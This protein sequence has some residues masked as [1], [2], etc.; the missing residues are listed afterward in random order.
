LLLL[1]HIAQLDVL[2]WGADWTGYSFKYQLLQIFLKDLPDEEIV[3]FV[4]A[5]DVILLRPLDELENSFIDFS[6]HTGA[7]IAVGYDRSSLIVRSVGA[8]QFGTISGYHLNSGTYI[9]YVKELKK[10]L[11]T[12]YSD[13]KLDDQKLL[14][15][16]CRTFPNSVYIDSASLFFLTINKPLGGSFYEPKLMRVD[17]DDLWFRGIRPFFAHGNGNTDMNELLNLLGYKMSLEEMRNM[18]ILNIKTR[19]KK[20]KW[21]IREFMDNINISGYT[22]SI[23]FFIVSGLFYRSSC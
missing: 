5:F 10:M 15:D 21:Y 18:D 12:I 22:L 2:G 8:L 14:T 20:A 9:G 13:P 17:K 16:Y 19:L 23:C 3:C 6:N 11:N 4:D 7:K 1:L